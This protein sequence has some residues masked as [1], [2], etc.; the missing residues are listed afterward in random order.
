VLVVDDDAADV[1]GAAV[2]VFLALLPQAAMIIATPTM[3]ATEKVVRREGAGC[4]VI[5]SKCLP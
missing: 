4:I 2:E 5:S 1:G 3:A